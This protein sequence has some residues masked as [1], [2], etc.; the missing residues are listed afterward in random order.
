MQDT[1]Q[2]TAQFRVARRIV[3]RLRAAGHEAYF[4]GGCVRD[5]VLGVSPKDY[6]VVT[7]AHP[8]IVLELFERTQAVGAQFG[9]VL[10]LEADEEA[11]DA[12]WVMTEVA[13]FRSDGSYLDGRRPEQV[14][15]SDSPRQDAVR[16]DFTINAMMLD[17]DRVI[18]GDVRAAVLDFTGG[19]AD[20]DGRLVRAIGDPVVRFTEDKLRLLRAVRFAA[21]LGFAIEPTTLRAIEQ[22]A[23]QVAQVSA[24]R[25]RDELTRML[26]EGHAK[27]AFELLDA[28]G[29]L[30]QVL[31]EI[32]RMKGVEQPPEFHPEGDVW[33]HTLL[34]LSHLPTGVAPELAWGALL[35][36]VG[37]PPTFVRLDRIRFNN[38]AN[39]GARMAEEITR[40]LRFSSASASQIVSLVENH[41]RF[42]DVQKMRESTRK[43]FF[44]L[45]EFPQHLEL[46]R[47]DCSSSHGDLCLY[48]FARSEFEN[49]PPEAVRPRLLVTGQDLIAAGY[50]PGPKFRE[51]LDA[52]ED[53]Q[54]EGEI[55]SREEGLALIRAKFA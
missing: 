43:R 18:A 38:H 55:T 2:S 41:M 1:A 34:V 33:I 4:V 19:L 53:A 16:R 5:L 45:R 15:Y 10:V 21:R 44:R 17:P 48:E 49:Q 24:E 31:P 26:T 28:T 39:V 46:H 6:D 37:K 40:R 54:L 13:T 29:L 27:R 14:I 11:E 52:A 3:D 47:M 23:P 30:A 51:M 20:L 32:S 50:R 25:V 42:G 9:V 12:Q 22:L 7:S 36:D 35:H 8:E